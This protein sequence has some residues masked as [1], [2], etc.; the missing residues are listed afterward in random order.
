[1]E[2]SL[3]EDLRK[4]MLRLG[5]E[6]IRIDAE[7][8]AKSEVLSRLKAIKENP[9][10]S[11]ESMP[12]QIPD[13]TWGEAILRCFKDSGGSAGLRQIYTNVAKYKPLSTRHNRHTVWGKRPAFQHE[14]RSFIS[15]L[16]ASGDLRKVSRGVYQITG[17]GEDKLANT[18]QEWSLAEEL[19]AL[20][21][22]TDPVLA[23][24]WDNLQDTAYDQL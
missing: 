3:V 13:Y 22:E 5:Y 9:I 24:I 7:L 16:V 18:R 11:T 4:E 20:T 2:S 23:E 17:Q 14:V 8:K 6:R 10:P 15:G 21:A 12:R 19:V 1:M